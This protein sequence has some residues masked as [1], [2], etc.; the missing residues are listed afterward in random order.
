MNSRT[1][2]NQ[3]EQE[4]RRQLEEVQQQEN[5]EQPLQVMKERQFYLLKT[6]DRLRQK[7]E[8]LVWQKQYLLTLSR[9]RLHR[10]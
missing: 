1:Q 6:L 4:Y 3:L 5:L 9:E 8:Y 10:R 2:L 7:G